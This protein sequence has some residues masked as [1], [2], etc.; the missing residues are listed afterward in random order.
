MKEYPLNTN[1]LV[2]K[3]GKIYSKR[4]KKFLTPKVNWDGYHRIQIWENNKCRMVSWHRVI[5]ETF[6]PNPDNKPVVN[7]KNGIKDDNRVENLEWCTQQENIQHSW[8]NGLSKSNKPVDM[9]DMDG[10][11]IQSFKSAV[12]A[13]KYIN[14]HGSGITKCVTGVREHCGNYKWRYSKTSNDYPERE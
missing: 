5:A 14:R 11:Y 12:E 13:G 3:D 7:H 1:Y 10:N 2:S 8:K 6:I 4:F 9:L